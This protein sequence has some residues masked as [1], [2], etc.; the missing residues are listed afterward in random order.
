MGG[1]IGVEGASG[2]GSTFWFELAP[3]EPPASLLSEF[4]GLLLSESGIVAQ[5]NRIVLYI[6]D[7]PSN[8][9]L[10]KRIAESRREVQL[11][12]ASQGRLGL[13]L[14]RAHRPDLI[15]L[16][17]HLPDIS[18]QEVLR[19]LRADPETKTIPVVIVSADATPE[20]MQRSLAAGAL[21]Y[22][23]KPLDIA[24]MLRLLDGVLENLGEA[25][26]GPRLGSSPEEV[27]V[28]DE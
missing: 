22:V 18:G 12:G 25:K 16:D 10:M 21:S 14:A 13:D 17:L 8:M 28:A 4:D 5:Q 6:E 3:A 2:G 27:P 20:Q 26:I 7:N 19:H 9:A 15:L 11:I 1:S 23:T 24:S